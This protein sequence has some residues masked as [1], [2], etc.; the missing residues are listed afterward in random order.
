MVSVV[1]SS[2]TIA[3]A[4]RDETCKGQISNQHTAEVV[5]GWSNPPRL[6]RRL[7]QQQQQQQCMTQI[8]KPEEAS[9][10]LNSLHYACTPH[11]ISPSEL[12]EN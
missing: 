4:E 8:C 1:Q 7:L 11:D 9:S 6:A 3:G 12:A 2:E 5:P 10:V